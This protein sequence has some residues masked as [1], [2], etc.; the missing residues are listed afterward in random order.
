MPTT[1]TATALLLLS[2]AT[3]L[4]Y[5]FLSAFTAAFLSSLICRWPPL[6][7]VATSSWPS[8]LLPATTTFASPS[9]PTTTS[10]HRCPLPRP[11]LPPSAISVPLIPAT[12]AGPYRSIHPKR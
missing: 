1:A 3:I 10:R 8:S 4:S 6:V 11:P 5:R 9:P 7:V 2:T 12:V